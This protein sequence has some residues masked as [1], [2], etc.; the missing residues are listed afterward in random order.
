M[1]Q[2]K[3]I[4]NDVTTIKINKK[5]CCSK[6]ELTSILQYKGIGKEVA[7]KTNWKWFYFKMNWK[8]IY[9]KN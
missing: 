1:L 4:K 6:N 5:Q 3:S 9:N 7:I 8:R 2:L